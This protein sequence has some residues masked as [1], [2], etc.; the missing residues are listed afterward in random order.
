MHNVVMNM[1]ASCNKA[2]NILSFCSL[3]FP[4]SMP[5]VIMISVRFSALSTTAT[6]FNTFH[7]VVN[8]LSFASFTIH[9]SRSSASKLAGYS[10]YDE[11]YYMNS[12]DIN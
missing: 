1:Q 6:S 4:A 9:L 3:S 5:T 2:I 8:N 10:E 11:T 7:E 12:F